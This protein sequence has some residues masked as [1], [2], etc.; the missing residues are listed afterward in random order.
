M[1][2]YDVDRCGPIR[3]E[4]KI[5]LCPNVYRK[6]RAWDSNSASI[7]S[8]FFSTTMAKDAN[9]RPRLAVPSTAFDSVHRSIDRRHLHGE[10]TRVAISRLGLANEKRILTRQKLPRWM[11][12]LC[13]PFFFIS[14]PTLSSLSRTITI[15]NDETIRTLPFSVLLFPV[16]QDQLRGDRNI[17]CEISLWDGER[18]DDGEAREKVGHHDCEESRRVTCHRDN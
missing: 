12:H 18:E 2:A 13:L 6:A 4:R 16:L 9:S 10:T 5:S 1:A 3:A 14:T 7:L 15:C 11:M 8:S 17:I